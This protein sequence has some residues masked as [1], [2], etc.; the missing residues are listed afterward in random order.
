[1]KEYMLNDY[2]SNLG[3]ILRHKRLNLPLTL[4]ELSARSGVSPSH[5]GRIENGERY[6][7]AFILQKIAMP[8][9]F[10]EKEL[11]TLAGYLSGKVPTIAE[12]AALYQG[13][14]IDPYVARILAQEPVDVQ[15]AMVGILAIFK[16]VAP[17][18]LKQNPANHGTAKKKSQAKR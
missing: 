3:K 5:L 4:Q 1:M 6:P 14:E 10:E 18:L 15:R 11:F 13:R 16:S 12:K 8:L 9:G 7:S 17:S 2:R